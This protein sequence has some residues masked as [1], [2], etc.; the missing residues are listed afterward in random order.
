[1]RCAV[2][3][4]KPYDTTF[5][6]RAN[7]ANDHEL[8][9]FEA[10]LNASTVA[11]AQGFEAIC[12]FVNDALSA[13][14]LQ[15][16]A[17][18]GTRIIAL[19]CAGFNNVDLKAATQYGITVARVPA[20]SPHAVAEHALA[21]VLSLNRQIHR[22]YNRVREGN[23][24]LDGLLGFDLHG[25]TVGIVGTG[26][27]GAI[28]GRLCHGLGCTVIASDPRPNPDCETFLAYT[29]LDDLYRRSDI[30]SLHCPLVPATHH[31]IDTKAI[32]LMKRGVMLINTSRGG[33]IDTRAVIQGLKSG[34]LGH[35]GI[36]VYEEEADLFF[37]DLSSTI[38]Q[39]D[40][41]SRLMT[42]PNVLI[43]GHQGFFTEE[44]LS[45]IA[46]T[47]LNNLTA[48]STGTGTLHAVQ[49]PA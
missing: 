47:T 34:H 27:I 24:R 45:S 4:T 35:L 46:Q 10:R 29:T 21:L 14:V 30:I 12:I 2:F 32:G 25:K 8:I 7:T 42:F 19:R 31:L 5:L 38:I 43:T 11:L 22:A 15:A 33:L 13:D 39:D 40:L 16:L 49:P 17:Q 28:F 37:E 48:F 9:F 18:G 1:M 36:D 23:F 44:A 20:Y 6:T 3:S 41:F 26:H